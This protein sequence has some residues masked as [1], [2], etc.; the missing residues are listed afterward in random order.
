VG[1]QR[2]APHGRSCVSWAAWG[3]I[4]K[5]SAAHM[6]G[7]PTPSTCCDDLACV[8][9]NHTRTC[10]QLPHV[11]LSEAHAVQRLPGARAPEGLQRHSRCADVIATQA[12]VQPSH[13]ALSRERRMLQ[14]HAIAHLELGVVK[15]AHAG[16]LDGADHAKDVPAAP[17]A[18]RARA[19]RAPV[20]PGC[21]ARSRAAGHH[22]GREAPAT[23]ACQ[24]P[25]HL[26][27]ACAGAAAASGWRCP[28]CARAP[29]RPP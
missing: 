14:H 1:G 23:D 17:R 5:C 10:V 16:P 8:P 12:G 28:R 21:E 7:R 15:Q 18:P 26:T 20:L 29:G 19:T 25:Q 22:A 4:P 27:R 13:A 3:R 24:C 9:H 6:P 11:R 2:E